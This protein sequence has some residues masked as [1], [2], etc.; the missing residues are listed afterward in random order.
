M[1][2]ES[3]EQPTQKTLDEDTIRELV[4]IRAH[5]L[6]LGRGGEHGRDLDDWL[7]AE[8]DVVASLSETGALKAQEAI[9]AEIPET[10]L[11]SEAAPRKR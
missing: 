6:F 8:Q 11:K 3:I 9:T 1:K 2:E 7:Q 10:T 5:E 4:S